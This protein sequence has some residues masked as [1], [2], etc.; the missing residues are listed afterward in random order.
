MRLALEGRPVATPAERY[1]SA[2]E[3][4]LAA[5]YHLPC[6]GTVK[7]SDVKSTLL[8]FICFSLQG[9]RPSDLFSF[10][11]SLILKAVHLAYVR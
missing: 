9:F 7:R 4:E 3:H 11:I 2:G 8:S 5:P 1:L 6:F 10:R